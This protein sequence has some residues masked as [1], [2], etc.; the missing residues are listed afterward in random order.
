MK[1][2][3]IV[4]IIL[5]LSCLLNM[6]YGY[7]ILVRYVIGISFAIMAYRYYNKNKTEFAIVWGALALLFQPIIKIPLERGVW[8]VVDVIVAI[9]LLWEVVKNKK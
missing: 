4:L 7:Y 2:L 5:L 8:N 9:V 3:Y 1:K 6:P